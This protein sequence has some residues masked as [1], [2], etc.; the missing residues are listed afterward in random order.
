MKKRI[1]IFLAAII[2]LGM[3][4][5]CAEKGKENPSSNEVGGATSNSAQ[6]AEL[7]MKLP[8]ENPITLDVFSWYQGDFD[9]ESPLIKEFE[10]K[11]N[12]KLVYNAPADGYDEK[13]SLMLTSASGDWPDVMLIGVAGGKSVAEISR[14]YGQ[15]GKFVKISEYADKLPNLKAYYE[16]YPDSK[17]LFEDEK[18]DSYIFPYIYPY[19]TIPTGFFVNS[20]A[21]EKENIPTPT[22]VEEIYEAAKKLKAAYPNSYPVTSYTVGETL[23]VWARAFGTTSTLGYNRG[24]DKYVYGP[25]TPEYKQML[26]YLNKLYKEELYDPQFP[27]YTFAGDDWRQTLATQKSFITESYVWEMQYENTNSV[28]SI[29]KNMNLQDQVDFRYMKPPTA[30]G[31]ESG[32]WGM[33]TV[34]PWYGLTVKAESPYVN[35]ILTLL[36]W[37][38]G[39][40]FFNLLGYGIEG[41]TYTMEGDKPKLMDDITTTDEAGKRPLSDYM[42]F[43]AGFNI[44]EIYPDPLGWKS[45]LENF[46]G[47]TTEQMSEFAIWPESWVIHLDQDTKD[48]HSLVSTPAGTLVDEMSYKFITGAA[49][50]D[51]YDKFINDLKGYGVEGMVEDYNKYYTENVKK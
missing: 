49:G 12:I 37:Q 1:A 34:S 40:E 23:T 22:S 26:E 35:E 2:T 31:K 28:N 47:Y 44:Y 41:E 17:S 38:L 8:L 42:S 11:T 20:K 15:A 27:Q 32:Y 29:A 3:A 9:P 48:R 39:E 43:Y 46:T 6:G 10:K 33:T 36:D 4:V 45:N 24:Q 21:F 7:P 13:E 14:Q 18:G 50:F 16:N 5:G 25:F 19:K 51:Q 30:N